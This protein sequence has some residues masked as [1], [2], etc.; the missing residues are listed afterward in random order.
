MDQKIP[1]F[2]QNKKEYG[3][4]NQRVDVAREGYFQDDAKA[5]HERNER[6]EKGR[7]TT[8]TTMTTTTTTTRRRC[9]VP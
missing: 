4:M 5:A 2:H 7:A 3:E 6:T 8:M 1:N 9:C